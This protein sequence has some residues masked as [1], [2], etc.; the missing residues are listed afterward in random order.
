MYDKDGTNLEFHLNRISNQISSEFQIR[1][2]YEYSM[3]SNLIRILNGVEMSSQDAVS[4]RGR[5]H[6][7]KPLAS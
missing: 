5:G 6:K 4:S 3:A 7:A 2:E 1:I